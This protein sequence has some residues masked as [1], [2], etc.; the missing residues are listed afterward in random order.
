MKK[1]NRQ[2]N[3]FYIPA[4]IIMFLFVAYPFYQA[5]HVSFFKW[6]GYS[7]NMKFIGL[8]NY[9]SMFQ[10]SNFWIAFRNTLIYGFGSTL[11]QNVIGL[12]VALL[13][14]SRYH[15]NGIVRTVTYMPIMIS[16]LIMGYI[17]YYFLTLNNGVFNDIIGLFGFEPVDWL[18]SGRTGII[19]ITLI[20]SWQYAGNCM[21]IYLAGLQN[22]PRVYYEAA[23]IDGV[24]KF[25]R[26]RYITIP[27]L[28]PSI[29]S[30][31][32][33]NLI[34]G[35]KLYDCVISLTNG[36]PGHRTESIMTYISNCYFQA[37]KAGY[38]AAI[39]I[40][41]FVFILF[42]SIVGNAYFDKKEVEM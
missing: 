10:D 40:F 37:E 31:V 22:V 26:F 28:M 13:V 9:L 34:G 8:D 16:G 32:I 2:M 7:Q 12:S 38:A 3:L 29:S 19:A 30:A 6:N 42:V 41:I 25:D 1:R 36:G 20:N 18:R 23:A 24:G 33:L 39:G 21:I 17:M 4:L 14:D 5:I 15:G 11:L 35:L 27:L